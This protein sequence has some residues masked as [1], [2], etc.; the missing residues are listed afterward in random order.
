[1][2]EERRLLILRSLTIQFNRFTDIVLRAPLLRS[3]QDST[4]E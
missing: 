2:I 4:C 1:M 3:N